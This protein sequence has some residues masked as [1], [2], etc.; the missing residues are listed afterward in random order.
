MS[1]EACQDG[2][3]CG[4]AVDIRNSNGSQF[5]FVHG[6]WEIPADYTVFGKVADD[7]LDILTGIAAE[8]VAGGLPEGEPAT[9]VVIEGVTVD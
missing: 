2:L 5:F 1:Q 3:I 6:R 8:G 4:P 9:P 7:D